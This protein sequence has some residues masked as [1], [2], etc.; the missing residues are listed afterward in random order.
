MDMSIAAVLDVLLKQHP[1]L[2]K[3]AEVERHWVWLTANLKDA[4][5]AATREAI[6]RRGIGFI[7][8]PRPHKLPSGKIAHWAHHCEHPI[9]FWRKGKSGVVQA[10]RPKNNDNNQ[11]T[12]NNRPDPLAVD[13]ETDDF[14]SAFA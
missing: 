9:A 5:Y 14:L 13:R 8:S 1:E 10:V 2:H 7:Y 6:G 3:T 12:P 4:Q 11:T